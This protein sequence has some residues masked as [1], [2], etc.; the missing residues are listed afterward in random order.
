MEE[1]DFFFRF[2]GGWLILSSLLTTIVWLV[3]PK[4]V[5]VNT[6]C[7]YTSVP[8]NSLISVGGKDEAGSQ[9]SFSWGPT[10]E[11]CKP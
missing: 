11:T 9:V 3:T 8:S 10:Q 7:L 2:C 4:L 6:S 5:S 1:T